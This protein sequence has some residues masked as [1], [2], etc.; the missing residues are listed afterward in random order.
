MNKRKTVDGVKA[1]SL[2]L[3]SGYLNFDTIIDYRFPFTVI[4]GGRAIGKT[5]GILDYCIKNKKQFIYMRR[6][7]S[8]VEQLSTDAL[9]PIKSITDFQG[10]ACGVKKQGKYISRL[11]VNENDAGI[12]V[13]L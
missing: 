8:M 12:M 11:L 5:F 3:D 4:V 1:P 7:Q 2:Y 13:A 10:K 9:N 6:S